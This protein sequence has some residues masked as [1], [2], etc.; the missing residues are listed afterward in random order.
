MAN[1]TPRKLIANTAA[2]LLAAKPAPV[3]NPSV[4]AP[5]IFHAFGRM[6]FGTWTTLT[7]LVYFAGKF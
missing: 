6:E 3:A 1:H 5:F 7:S 4:A 2:W